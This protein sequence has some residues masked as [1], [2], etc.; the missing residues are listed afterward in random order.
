MKQARIMR[1][2][3]KNKTKNTIKKRVQNISI[4]EKHEEELLMN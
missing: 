2:Q 1:G 4:T 3:R